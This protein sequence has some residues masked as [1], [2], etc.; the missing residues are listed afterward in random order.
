MFIKLCNLGR[1]AEV[2]YAQGG[3]AVASLALAYSIGFGDQKR[4]QWIEVSL[5]GERAEKMAAHLTKGTKLLLTAD[6]LEVEVFDKRDGSTGAKLKA[7]VVNLEFVG[8]RQ[9]KQGGQGQF[10]QLAPANQ[11]NSQAV[12][13]HA[14]NYAKQSQGGG[15]WDDDIPFMRL[16]PMEGG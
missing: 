4:T 5:W 12:T 13:G 10:N 2:R 16:H 15:S 1:D 14:N 7:R 3:K 9:D 6:D 11:P 8:S